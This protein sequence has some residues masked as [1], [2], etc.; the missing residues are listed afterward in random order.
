MIVH[1][2]D[3]DGAGIV[4]DLVDHGVPDHTLSGTI[5]VSDTAAADGLLVESEVLSWQVDVSGSEVNFSLADWAIYLLDGPLHITKTRIYTGIEP[6]GVRSGFHMTGPN[7]ESY[8]IRHGTDYFGVTYDGCVFGCPLV[9]LRYDPPPPLIVHATVA[10][11]EPSTFTFL[12]L[13]LVGAGL[14]GWRN[15]TANR[16]P[17]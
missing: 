7:L 8:S 10:V 4:Y 9:R 12:C 5:T 11:P 16:D 2:S 3:S 1:T 15:R 13:G 6:D 17:S 14:A